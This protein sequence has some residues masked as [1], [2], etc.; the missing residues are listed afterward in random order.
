[1][2]IFPQSLISDGYHAP[3]LLRCL[4]STYIDG[5]YDEKK[6]ARRP[7]AKEALELFEGLV[8][9]VPAYNLQWRLQEQNWQCESH[10]CLYSGCC[11]S[12]RYLLHKNKE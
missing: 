5:R 2:G 8:E 10:K 6:P 9:G 4:L 12:Q 11:I 7:T 1:M 3:D